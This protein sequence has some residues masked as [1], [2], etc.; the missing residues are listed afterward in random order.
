MKLGL[1]RAAGKNETSPYEPLGLLYIASYLEKYMNFKDVIITENIDTLLKE[2]PDI[3]GISIYT[4]YLSE[5]EE[6]INKIKEELGIPVIVGGPHVTLLPDFLPDK[7]DIAVIGEGEQTILELLELYLR[8]KK[9]DP[10]HLVKIPG[11]I[12]KDGSKRIKTQPRELIYSLDLIPPPKR[13]LLKKHYYTPKI[14]TGRG[15]PYKCA[16]CSTPVLWHKFR[17]FSNDYIYKELLQ[18]VDSSGTRIDIVDDLFS[19]SIQKIKDFSKFIV[20][21]GIEKEVS[22]YVNI[23][24]DTFNEEM[25]YLLKK[26][27]TTKVFIGFESASEKILKFYNKKQTVADNQRVIDLCYTYDIQ[28]I[29]SF[30][31]GAPIETRKDIKETY[32]FIY[33]NSE[34]IYNFACSFLSPDP[35]TAIWEYIK[36]VMPEIKTIDD[37]L[38]IMYSTNWSEHLTT[39]ELINYYRKICSIETACH[40][41]LNNHLKRV[42]KFSTDLNRAGFQSPLD[43]L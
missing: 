19:I 9:F 28:I 21:R 40:K 27:N 16:F 1:I 43:L 7:S 18:I 10:Y 8:E 5:A 25:C 33:K 24:A 2:K 4:I 30:I 11:I 22:F 13:E 38:E 34:K 36:P 3:A 41:H 6:I 35:G 14:L 23:R 42:I 12:F 15:C 39:E 29:G 31:I 17:M 32:N 20:S 37:L 26:M